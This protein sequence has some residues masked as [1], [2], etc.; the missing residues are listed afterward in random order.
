MIRVLFP[1]PL[2]TARERLSFSQVGGKLVV[3][4]SRRSLWKS[5]YEEQEE[6]FPSLRS[7]PLSLREKI[8]EKGLLSFSPDDLEI[9]FLS[10]LLPSLPF[11]GKTMEGLFPLPLFADHKRCSSLGWALSLRIIPSSP[12]YLRA[13][14]ERWRPLSFSPPPEADRA[15]WRNGL[16]F[17]SIF[18]GR[19]QDE[20]TPPPVFFLLFFFGKRRAKLIPLFPPHPSLLPKPTGFIGQHSLFFPLPP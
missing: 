14:Y 9:F 19:K 8:W 1:S 7:I 17:P 13:D 2:R 12:P 11:G 16:F 5:I 10:L 3:F 15:C 6:F 20:P 18:H 4:S